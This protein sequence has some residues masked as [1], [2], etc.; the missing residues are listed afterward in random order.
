MK[1]LA[2]IVLTFCMIS[3]SFAQDLA[4]RARRA[5]RAGH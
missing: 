3:A 2:A 5:T 4:G 1:T